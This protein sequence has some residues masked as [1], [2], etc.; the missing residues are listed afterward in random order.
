MNDTKLPHILSTSANLLGI[1]FF[2]ITGIHITDKVEYLTVM[3][4]VAGVS[5]L[6]LM[7]CLFSYLSIRSYSSK[8]NF[9]FERIADVL[10]MMSI[11][12][13]FFITLALAFSIGLV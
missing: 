9:D 7:S 5:L 11:V 1:C 8:N 10:F 12:M 13:L 2:I 6:L 3:R 4:A